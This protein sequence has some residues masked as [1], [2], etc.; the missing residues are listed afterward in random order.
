MALIAAA[1]GGGPSFEDP[2]LLEFEDDLTT[3]G[4]GHLQSGVSFPY[5][6]DPPYGGPHSGNLLP[7]GIYQDEQPPERYL[8]TMEHGAIVI[9][10]QPDVFAHE[11]V[12][13]LR[14]LGSALL[15]QG[16]RIVLAPNRSMES[17]VVVASWGRLLPLESGE[18]AAIR[19]FVDAF[20][21][22]APESISRSR[23]C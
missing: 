21:D 19:A 8:H 15:Q 6:T 14:Q 23:A 2:R 4:Q 13:A 16:E 18:E 3:P 22:D 17:P 10:Y 1:C 20:E 9:H 7:C 12:A 11:D 5:A